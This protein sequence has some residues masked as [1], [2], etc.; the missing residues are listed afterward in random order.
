MKYPITNTNY[1]VPKL[2]F[3]RDIQN[4][5]VKKIKRYEYVDQRDIDQIGRE[6][7]RTINYKDFTIVVLE[8]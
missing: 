6:L 8:L 2:Q 1:E 7:K 5:R 4:L 3:V